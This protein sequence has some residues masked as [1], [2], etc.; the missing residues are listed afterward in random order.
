MPETRQGFILFIITILYFK[1]LLSYYSLYYISYMNADDSLSANLGRSVNRLEWNY[2]VH[3]YK[4]LL[5]FD[6]YF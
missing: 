4:T 3:S 6:K 1:L 2:S 5:I